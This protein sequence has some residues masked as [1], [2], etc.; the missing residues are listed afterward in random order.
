MQR[1]GQASAAWRN[2]LRAAAFILI[3]WIGVEAIC[4]L[5]A[6]DAR[7]SVA[8][9]E[10]TGTVLSSDVRHNSHRFQGRSVRDFFPI[11]KYAYSVGGLSFTSE[12]ISGDGRWSVGE[13]STREFVAKHPAGSSVTVYY[14]PDRPERAVLVRGAPYLSRLLPWVRGFAIAIF[15]LPAIRGTV[16]WF[17]GR[18]G[19]DRI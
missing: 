15:L 10:T 4:W 16:G 8:W 11:V 6:S 5:G 13:A 18:A 2:D 19:Q 12:Q 9:P 14:D 17:R 3:L 1:E 7:K